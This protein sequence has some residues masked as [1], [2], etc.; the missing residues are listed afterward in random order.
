M[1]KK[2]KN[3]QK[4]NVKNLKR[5]EIEIK[6]EVSNQEKEGKEEISRNQELEQAN[7]KEEIEV[8]GQEETLKNQ[9]LEEKQE[10]EVK[11]EVKNHEQ[12]KEEI[13]GKN[14]SCP[15]IHA[16]KI[17]EVELQ[18]CLAVYLNKQIKDPISKINSKFELFKKDQKRK[19]CKYCADKNIPQ[20]TK[21]DDLDLSILID[22]LSV[23]EL[24]PKYVKSL[25]NFRNGL[26]HFNRDLY[27]SSFPMVKCC[28]LLISHFFLG[29]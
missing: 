7:L 13:Q 24:F 2:R 21:L 17:L 12:Q 27:W 15:S 28:F 29:W 16:G 26:S 25:K 11:P 14:S 6:P 22:L 8:K 18:A 5:E 20:I 23:Y 9:E 10:S 3:Q 4:K 1:T 19:N